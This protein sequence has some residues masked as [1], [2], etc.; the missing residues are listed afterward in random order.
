MLIA[1]GRFGGGALYD[2]SSVGGDARSRARGARALA[3]VLRLG[4]PQAEVIVGGASVLV[5]GDT[6]AFAP[7][8]LDAVPDAAFEA[9]R[10][11][12]VD[13]VYDGED[14]HELASTLGRS[15]RSIVEA[16]T[17]CTYEVEVLGFLPG[18]AYLAE[19]DPDLRRPRRAIPRRRVPARSVGIAGRYT[20]IY[21]SVSPG[22]WLLLGRALATQPFDASRPEPFL[23]ALGDRVRFRQRDPEPAIDRAV[24]NEAPPEGELEVLFAP[25]SATVQDLGRPGHRGRGVPVGGAWDVPLHLA[26]N[27]ALGNVDTAATIELPRD[28]LEARAGADMWWS[29]DGE[30]PRLARAGDTI[31]VPAHRRAVRYF[32]VEG[33]F[34]GDV[35][36]GS[37]STHVSAGFGG[38]RGRRLRRGDRL[39]LAR[40]G[41]RLPRADGL[42][43]VA[44]VL[45]EVPLVVEPAPLS[46]ALAANALEVLCRSE[47]TISP[48]FDRIGTRL[49]GAKLERRTSDADAPLPMVRGAVQVATDGTPIVLG[50]DGATTGGYPVIATLPPAAQSAFARLRPGRPVRFVVG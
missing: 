13:V 10:L 32:G 28:R 4:A 45:A 7:I 22:G 25:A 3:D 12:V 11:H 35:V 20:G 23:F 1:P 6:R 31:S 47:L 46:A 42:S 49:D 15:P 48:H 16:H 26:T 33:G 29:V 24:E 14:L 27:H 37:R 40:D 2:V 41:A 9:G 36:L 18:F 30:P 39:K 34:A 17:A 38:F 8:D 44:A 43:A 21:P 19:L 50:P 5:L